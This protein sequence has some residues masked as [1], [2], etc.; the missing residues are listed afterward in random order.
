VFNDERVRNS[1]RLAVRAGNAGLP[2]CI[3]GPR[4]SGRTSFAQAL[5]QKLLTGGPQIAIDCGQTNQADQADQGRTFA[6]LMT[7]FDDRIGTLDQENGMFLI[8]NLDEMRGDSADRIIQFV[9]RLL[10][11]KPAWHVVS[12]EIVGIDTDKPWSS[13]FL[14]AYQNLTQMKVHLPKLIARNDF[15]SVATHIL[16]EISSG[17]RLSNSALI[18]LQKIERPENMS[19]LANQ[20]RLLVVHCSSGIIREEHIE[21]IFGRPSQNDDV[22]ARCQ[23]KAVR[24]AKC[25]EINRVFKQCHSNVA[26][27]A[28]TLNVSR[29]T[30][31]SHIPK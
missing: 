22:C 13:E 18:M 27:T 23:G 26:L 29:N 20:L 31:Y 5:H 25:R 12:T 28:R 7:D 3:S 6:K 2:I 11:T 10:T 17:H 4:G 19:D 15:V 21:R 14:K 9:G 1:M 30:V 8:E 16:A 24:E